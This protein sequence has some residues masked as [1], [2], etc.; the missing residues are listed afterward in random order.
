MIPP[1]KTKT[2][3]NSVRRKVIEMITVPSPSAPLIIYRA[4]P[5]NSIRQPTADKIPKFRR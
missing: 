1:I 4:I 2:D 5:A 3:D